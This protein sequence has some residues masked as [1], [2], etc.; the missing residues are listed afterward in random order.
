MKIFPDKDTFI[1]LA[2]KGNLIPVCA[3]MMADMETPVSVYA[4]LRTRG[5]S[6]LLESVTGGE[7]IGRYSFA[8][9]RPRKSITAWKDKT[10]ITDRDGRSET[11]STPADPLS[12][13][14]KIM[15]PY[16]SVPLPDMPPFTGGA[17]GFAG[18][19]SI[20]CIEPSVPL[21]VKDE[22]NVPLLHFMIMD[23][24]V[25]FDHARQRIRLC[26]NACIEAG[27]N[28]AEVWD[29]AVIELKVLLNT[30]K[31]PRMLAPAPLIE[32]IEIPQPKGNFSRPAF[33][34]AVEKA[35]EYIHAGDGVQIVLSQ[36]FEREFSGSPI[37]IYRVLRYINP[38][39]YMF[40]LESGL[41]FQAVGASPEVHVRL[42]NGNVEIRPI[43]GTRPRGH[44]DADDKQLEKE[45]LADEKELAEHL[46][47][48]DLARNDIGRVCEIGSVKVSEY[49]AIE[50]YSHVMHIVSQVEGQIQAGK[51]AFDL[52][53]ATFPAGT[54]SGAPK[55]RAMQI[56]SELEGTQRGF[57]G[58]ALGYFSFSGNHDSCI[59][60][61]SALLKEGKAFVQA[62][63]GLV[64]DSIPSSEYQE[65]INK[66]M[67]VMKAIAISEEMQK[68]LL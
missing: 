42:T 29:Q 3:D 58:G 10:I 15:T 9:S 38:S 28:P 27:Q 53:R 12:I 23:S 6:F 32:N 36:R 34:A 54:L 63:A 35:R 18:Y 44:N 31:T 39:P 13:V 24:V 4:K 56:I 17:V 64:A 46:M 25:M 49:T 1:H 67:S 60:I 57:Y 37:D 33:E 21:P 22:L 65:T 8:G 14:E 11:V 50:R 52:F 51:N 19:E 62:G 20:H 68:S 47:L 41:G 61:R 7:H 59:A 2:Q 5:A 43:A 30:L 40:I 26:V 16:R 48:V 45:L 66:S 55:V